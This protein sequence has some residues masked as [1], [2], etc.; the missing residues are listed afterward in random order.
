MK[1]RFLIPMV[2]MT[3]SATNVF[4][5]G[6][7]KGKGR[8]LHD[9]LEATQYNLGKKIFTGKAELPEPSAEL[10]G[11]QTGQLT[12][13]QSLLPDKARARTDVTLLAGRLS[14]EQSEALAY[15]VSVRYKVAV[16]Q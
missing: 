16:P 9:R 3:L 8:R 14:D 5:S 1:M 4:A 12:A 2:V 13:L 15:Y 11:E 7:Y 10:L 6:S